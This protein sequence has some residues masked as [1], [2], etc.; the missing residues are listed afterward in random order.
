[1]RFGRNCVKAL[2]SYPP[3]AIG[4]KT[5][6]GEEATW[7]NLKSDLSN[8]AKNRAYGRIDVLNVLLLT[9]LFTVLSLVTL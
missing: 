1:M 9:H 7:S 6:L 2:M 8:V 3:E 5:L 4:Y